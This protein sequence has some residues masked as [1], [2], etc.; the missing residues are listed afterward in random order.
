MSKRTSVYLIAFG[1]FLLVSVVLVACS[2]ATQVTPV[3][4]KA[5]QATAVPQ[6]VPTCPAAPAAPACPTAAPQAKAPNQDAWA[7]SPHND[8]KSEVF[9]HWN[10][11]ADKSVPTSCAKCHT[12]TG[13]SDYLGA[14]GSAALKVDKAQ[15]IGQTITCDACHNQAT[16]QLTSVTFNSV[17]GTGD[18]AKPVT[19][20]G[21]GPEARCMVCHQ[22]TATKTQVDAQIAKFQAGDPLDADKAVLPIKS[23]DTTTNFG[24]INV[25]YFASALTLYG[26]EVH[27]GYEYDGKL[28][29]VKF[30]HVPGYDTCVG[31][32]DPHTT[33]VKIAQCATC[34]EGVKT[35]DDLKNIRMV[36]SSKDYDGDGDVKEG[37]AKEIEGLQAVLYK[38]IQ[39]YVADFQGSGIIYDAAT[40]PYFLR[41]MDHDGKADK[42]DKG[43]T[44]AY[45]TWTPRLLKAAYN[46]QVS[47]KDPGNFAHGNKYIVQ[48]LVDSTTDLVNTIN[49]NLADAKKIDISKLQRDDAGHFAGNTMPFR[50]WDA[51]GMVP[52]GCAKC[53]SAVGL[54]EFIEGGGTEAVTATGTTLV[55]GV[56][57]APTVNGFQCSTCHDETAFPKVYAVNSVVFPSGKSATFGDANPSNI[58]LECHQ[59]RE[60]SV[61]LTNALK[62]LEPDTASDKIRFK[63]VHYLGAGATWF[64]SQVMGMF[65]YA[66]KQYA[67]AFTHAPGVDSCTTCHDKHAL[68]PNTS[69]CKGCHGVD[70]PT[71]IRMNS[72][73][74]YDGDGKTDGGVAVELKGMQTKLYAELQKYAK[75]KAKAGLI[76]D[77]NAY[78]YFYLDAN[79]DGTPDKNDKGAAIQYNAWTPKLLQAAYN[80]QYSFKDPGAYVHNF[81]YVGQALYDSIESLGGAA[82]VQGMTRPVTPAATK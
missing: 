63:N 75:D 16:Q 13:Y 17:T 31:C 43:A 44:L 79:N 41:D 10:E 2:G 23:G 69:A 56:G 73:A 15:P 72:K 48:L 4:T 70:D 12:T 50:D 49:P 45:T 24:F 26:S 67:G 55:T 74:D 29:D 65:Q 40:Y 77:T 82:A 3:P 81:T 39:S 78:P 25:H 60:S 8:A 64:G 52:A 54:P 66:D 51:E 14:D 27:G 53:H 76:Y 42:D 1:L 37:M 80:L 35:V 22:G 5:E 57:P 33:Q 6:V 68:S 36:S 18:Q 38:A 58:C 34:H 11:T 28:Y 32:H 62:G 21:L 19:I 47:I 71:M 61:S 7:A 46:Y 9:T 59:G 30:D 20:T